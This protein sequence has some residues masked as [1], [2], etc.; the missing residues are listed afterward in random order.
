V[1]TQPQRQQYPIRLLHLICY[2]MD[3][4]LAD[5]AVQHILNYLPSPTPSKSYTSPLFI[6]IQGPQGIG[7]TTLT[8]RLA[9]TLSKEPY[10]LHVAKLST[11]DLFLSHEALKDLGRQNSR[12]ALLQGRG[13]PGTHDIRLGVEV[14][15]GLRE[16]NSKGESDTKSVLIPSY[17]KS[18]H[19]GQGDRL[20]K[21]EWTKVKGGVDVVILEG[22]SLG[23]YP[24][25]AEVIQDRWEKRTDLGWPA[26]IELQNGIQDIE[27]INENLKECVSEWYHYLSCFIQV[28]TPAPLDR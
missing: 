11:D 10:S 23:F 24:L 20:P 1:A 18:L 7:K 6:G 28:H 8:A 21:S 9:S 4:T 3:L 2:P 25:S 27:E 16:I 5:I 22:W 14:L 15:K 12:N 26:T 13:L 19:D 17:D